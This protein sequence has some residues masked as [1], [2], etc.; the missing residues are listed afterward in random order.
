MWRGC[1][2]YPKGGQSPVKRELVIFV[3]IQENG[4]GSASKKGKELWKNR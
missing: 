1:K 4:G 2:T 3:N